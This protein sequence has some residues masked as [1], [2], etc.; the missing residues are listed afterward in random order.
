L[1]TR[2]GRGAGAST[3]GPR[4]DVCEAEEADTCGG[5]DVACRL[6][7]GRLADD[8]AEATGLFASVLLPYGMG[9]PDAMACKRAS[10]SAK[11]ALF[12]PN[13][14]LDETGVPGVLDALLVWDRADA[15][16]DAGGSTG[17]RCSS[18]SERGACLTRE[19]RVLK[20]FVGTARA[21]FLRWG[22]KIDFFGFFDVDE[23][24][25][26]RGRDGV[27]KLHV[28]GS[29]ELGLLNVGLIPPI[30]RSKEA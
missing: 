21:L 12:G 27:W 26:E 11:E 13:A 8:S 23:P 29:D 9:L 10:L 17:R 14:G 24:N 6:R 15:D 22:A 4:G 19:A 5:G 28:D 18:M 7:I 3:F 1:R 25:S 30:F 20:C 2:A 16:D